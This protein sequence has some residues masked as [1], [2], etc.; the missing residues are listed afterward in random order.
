MPIYSFKNERTGEI[1]GLEYEMGKAPGFGC[2]SKRKPGGDR[3]RRVFEKENEVNAKTND[4]FWNYQVC[5]KTDAAGADFYNKKGVP[6]FKNRASAQEWARKRT[7]RG[8]A[9][10]FQ[11]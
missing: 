11:G 10:E 9:T 2:L 3:F 1:V 6:G 5:R 7:G 4:I 8:L